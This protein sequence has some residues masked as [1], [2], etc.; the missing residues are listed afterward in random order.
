[1]RAHTLHL[2]LIALACWAMMTDCA[3][4]ENP[5]PSATQAPAKIVESTFIIP[6][7][8]YEHVH[9]SSIV[10]LPDGALLAA[11]FQGSGE[12][13]ADDVRIMGA[14]KPAGMTKWS[15][16]FMLADTPGHPDCN[17]VLWIDKDNRLWLFWSAILSNDWDSSL[18]K[19][20]ISTNYMAT[21]G[22]PQWDWQDNLHIKP[23]DFHQH[24]LAGWKPLLATIFFVPRSIRAE[25]SATPIP[26]L[27]L[28]AWKPLVAVMLLL[29][30]PVAVN[31]WRRRRTGRTGWKRF[32]LRA[33]AMYASLVVFGVVGAI[34][35][36]SLHS[37]NKLNQRLGWL[38]ANKP[39]QLAS[40]E[41]V[42]PLYSD[43]FVASI[44]AISSDAG[45]T[46]E[47]S[48]PLVGYGNIQ[49]SLV[50]RRSGELVA[51]MRESGLR[52]R[53]RC[54]VSSNRGR[55]WSSVS[56]SA[57]PNP[58]AKVAIAALAN[59]DWVIAYNPLVDGRHSLGLA[60]SHDEGETWRPFHCLDEALPDKGSFSY[61]CLT[62]TADGC[63]QVTYT[64]RRHEGGNELKSIKH[65][66]L[67]PPGLVPE[68]QLAKSPGAARL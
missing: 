21:N 16:P 10:E 45:A 41:I 32:A 4:A 33:T 65:V 20:R 29:G 53:I 37:S 8:G 9:S 22:P 64:H 58:G 61:P 27:L 63:I 36:F 30:G 40:G 13:G 49:P 42:L 19:Y 5:R 46:W 57:L 26:L 12:S 34:G 67:R 39:V 44:M 56:E 66:T 31:A 62:E 48:Q 18:V 24:M 68:V 52:K 1:M 7:Q 14:R 28:D 6:K 17:P 55:N 11:W 25:M 50:E 51:W 59:D 60:I 15:E 23:A 2:T 47:A 35:Y 43:R 3:N 54:S 38:T